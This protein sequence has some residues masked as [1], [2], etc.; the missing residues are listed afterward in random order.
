MQ[1]LGQITRPF[2][3][4]TRREGHFAHFCP[5][6]DRG[7]FRLIATASAISSC[8]LASGHPFFAPAPPSAVAVVVK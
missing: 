6:L 3:M 2:A 8:A 7:K 1:A 4:A 5:C